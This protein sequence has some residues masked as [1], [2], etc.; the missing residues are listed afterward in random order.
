MDKTKLKKLIINNKAQLKIEL[1]MKKLDPD[2]VSWFGRIKETKA[3][4][5]L[6]TDIYFPPQENSAGFVTTDD[7]RFPMWFFN[8]FIKKGIQN[9]VR[10]HGHT[11]PRFSAFSSG[12]DTQQ[13]SKLIDEVDDYMIQLIINNRKEVYCKIWTK[14]GKQTD[15]EVIFDYTERIN[16]VLD[17]MCIVKPRK[18]NYRSKWTKED[19]DEEIEYYREHY[20]EMFDEKG[21]QTSIFDT[22]LL[23][24]EDGVK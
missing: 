15:L 13:F 16:R 12:T 9:Q 17:S 1:A 24:G 20:P 3:G 19:R 2:E 7:E 11:H 23:G 8:T 4:D 22:P 18:Y 14:D 5:Y 21:I 6:L 10:L